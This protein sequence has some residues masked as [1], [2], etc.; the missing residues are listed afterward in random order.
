[1]KA[2]PGDYVIGTM[3]VIFAVIGIVLA[4]NAL[5]LEMRVFGLSLAAFAVLF[6]FGQIRRHHN[7]VDRARL[8]PARASGSRP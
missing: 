3:M 7:A 1:M 6:V 2:E 8:A 4:G 5:D